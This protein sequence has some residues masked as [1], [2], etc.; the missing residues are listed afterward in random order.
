[1]FVAQTRR[2]LLV[3]LSAALLPLLFTTAARAAFPGAD[4][5]IVFNSDRSI[6]TVAPGSTHAQRLP[7]DV[8]GFGG[9]AVSPDGSRIAYA[10]SHV[11][12][13]M[14]ADGSAP[15]RLTGPDFSDNPTFSPNGRQI[16]YERGY[17]IWVMNTDGSGQHSITPG[18]GFDQA[19][20]DPAWSPDGRRIAVTHNQQVWAMNA[21]GSAPVDL[22]PPDL[23]CP[24]MTRTMGGSQPD[25][26]PDGSRIAFTGPVTCTNSLGTDIW[27][28]SADGSGKADLIGDNGTEDSAPVFSPSGRQIAFTRND[29]NGDPQLV[30]MSADGGGMTTAALGL[31]AVDGQA[32]AVAYTPPRLTEAVSAPSARRGHRV[33][34]TGRVLPAQGSGIIRLLIRRGARVVARHRLALRRSRYRWA[35]TPSAAGR[36]RVVAQFTGATGQTAASPAR[37][38]R[39][40]P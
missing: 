11:I 9:L 10:A 34:I 35:Y 13:V 2:A 7:E 22:T 12:Y 28:M 4:G 36:Y 38:F 29:A 25:W 24:L 27:V 40:R 8:P 32:W 1:M 17:G 21:D 39:V 18:A 6:Y 15:R 31:V 30:T 19:Y 33:L 23:M 37:T 26:S 20:Y 3:A 16:A 5:R 14:N